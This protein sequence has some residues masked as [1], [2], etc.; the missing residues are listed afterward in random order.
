ML[1]AGIG[2][3]SKLF[4]RLCVIHA[5]KKHPWKLITQRKFTHRLCLI[6]NKK[7]TQPVDIETYFLLFHVADDTKKYSIQTRIAHKLD[8]HLR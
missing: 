3:C 4:D 1:H 7:N 5:T 8:S 6:H 2:F